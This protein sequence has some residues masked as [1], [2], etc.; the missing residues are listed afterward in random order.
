[1]KTA[2]EMRKML[3]DNEGTV[4]YSGNGYELTLIRGIILGQTRYATVL[5]AKFMSTSGDIRSPLKKFNQ[6]AEKYNLK[7]EGDE[8]SN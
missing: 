4:T 7:L 8:N 2:T 1:M 3:Q 5:N 6:L